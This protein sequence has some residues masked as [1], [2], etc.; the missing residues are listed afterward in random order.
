VKPTGAGEGIRT[1]GPNL[2]SLFPLVTS[3][4]V[5]GSTPV[6]PS[7][8]WQFGFGVAM[9]SRTG[10]RNNVFGWPR[11]GRLRPGE[12]R[13]AARSAIRRPGPASHLSNRHGHPRRICPMNAE[14]DAARPADRRSPAFVRSASCRHPTPRSAP[15][16]G[17]HPTTADLS[18]KARSRP[19]HHRPA[20]HP[21]PPAPICPT[22]CRNRP[23]A[24]PS[25]PCPT[26]P[27]AARCADCSP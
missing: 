2:F 18:D 12:R 6:P 10:Y 20:G 22:T 9:R 24:I 11:S 23:A 5:S 19:H 4:G 14:S 3:F 21:R 1:L 8:F 16:R 17:S 26:P 27:G 15:D 7:I 25:T 13:H